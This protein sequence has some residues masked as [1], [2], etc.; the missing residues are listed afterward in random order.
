M[1]KI[2]IVIEDKADGTTGFSFNS[3]KEGCFCTVAEMK[4]FDLIRKAIMEVFGPATSSK[5][6]KINI[7]RG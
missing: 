3:P 1:I 7:G 5:V 4:T 2:E 6:R